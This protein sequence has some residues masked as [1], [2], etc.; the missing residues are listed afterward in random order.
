MS[1]FVDKISSAPHSQKA[2][3]ELAKVRENCEKFHISS[4]ARQ[5]EAAESMLKDS[6]PI[7]VAILGQFKA[8]K[9]SF[10][11]SLLGERVL[12]VG[13]V[14]VTTVICRLQYGPQRKAVVSFFN[15]SRSEIE[16]E[17][18]DEFTSEAKNPS[19]I[20]NVEMVDIELPSLGEYPG[21]RFVDT[22]GL[23]S[24]FAYHHATSENWLPEVGAALL[25]ISSDRPLSENDVQLIRELLQ[26]T[27]NVILLLTKTDLLTPDQQDEI[28]EFF[29]NAIRKEFNRVF[30]VFLYSTKTDTEQLRHKLDVEVFFKLSIDRDFEFRK[31]LQYKTKSLAGSC[32]GYLDIALKTAL[33]SD[34]DKEELRREVIDEKVNSDFVREDLFIISR[35]NQKQT[36]TVIN[37]YLEQFQSPLVSRL[38]QELR[39]DMSGWNYNLWKLTRAY[40]DWLSDKLAEKM[41]AISKTE[42][43]HFYV[44][45]K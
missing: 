27:P 15:N 18:L 1:S 33:Q 14:P 30:P 29:N 24:V 10:I 34:S 6:S 28:V 4:L 44:T 21:L 13:V 31:I 43:K 37:Q 23:G 25:A 7:D 5:L 32:L 20:K 41:R 26:Y 3:L 16:L 19:N 2:L 17:D 11:N 9:S 45:L 12:P 22:P 35:E 38:K 39:G 42:H 36:R 8:G 40:E